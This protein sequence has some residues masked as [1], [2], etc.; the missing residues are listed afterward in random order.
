MATLTGLDAK[1]LQVEEADP[2]ANFAVGALAVM[3]GPLL[4]HDALLEA[5]AARVD[6]DRRFKQVV[7]RYPFDLARPRAVVVD[8]DIAEQVH[9]IAV[10]RPGDDQALFGLVSDVMSWRLHH[11]DPLWECWVVE[12]V[13]E[14]RWAIL[15]KTH[16]SIADEAEAMRMLTRLCDSDE[17]DP[18]T[19]RDGKHSARALNP[20]RWIGGMW[21]STTALTAA[22]ARAV[23]ETVDLARVHERPAACPLAGR[24][25]S[26]RRY[27]AVELNL[28]D[29]TKV[30]DAFEVTA[31][32]I[33]LAAMSGSY[34]GLLM[35]HGR[36][37]HCNSLRA[38][39][40]TSAHSLAAVALPVDESDP[41]QRLRKAHSRL[42]R[43][44]EPS[45]AGATHPSMSPT[46]LGSHALPWPSPRG[47]VSLTPIE[48][49]PRRRLRF[50]G[51]DIVRLLPIPAIGMGTRA[52]LAMVSYAGKLVVGVTSDDEAQPEVAELAH[53][54]EQTVARLSAIST[55]ARRS[56]K[57]T[58][59]YLLPGEPAPSRPRTRR[60]KPATNSSSGR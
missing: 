49:D 7:R 41:V 15:L 42:T 53:S 5:L 50:I 3:D 22:T 55:S 25:T 45:G 31:K 32:D 60:H 56:N 29:V 1:F 39:V 16:S 30:C 33:A 59:L 57:K 36:Q 10:P 43:A 35:H 37:A 9:H 38:L 21:R 58:M 13:S 4:D 12:G 11:D 51:R 28:E 6:T 2:N 26:L 8:E 44:D 20:L 47:V 54:V 46:G 27:A 40:P 17:A 18:Q 24:V 34:R 23:A 52:G 48:C 14:N 19:R